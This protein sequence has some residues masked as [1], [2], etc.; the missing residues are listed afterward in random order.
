MTPPM[1]SARPT[2]ARAPATSVPRPAMSGQ[3]L[4]ASKPAASASACSSAAG[5]PPIHALPIPTLRRRDRLAMLAHVPA[6]W[7]PV[8]RHRRAKRRR[9]SN[10][11][12]HAPDLVVVFQVREALI[13]FR[14]ALEC[15]ARLA[16]LPVHDVFDL[17]GEFEILVGDP[18]GGV[19]LQADLD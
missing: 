17:L 10:G 5:F 3:R 8:R 19:V 18:L 2:A 15:P 1:R 13:L 9:S 14:R 11:Y 16:G 6:K 7:T 12:E 4:A